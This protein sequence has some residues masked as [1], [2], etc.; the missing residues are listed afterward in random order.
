MKRLPVFLVILLCFVFADP[1]STF[2]KEPST[3]TKKSGL[4][5]YNIVD[6][7]KNKKIQVEVRGAG[8]SKVNVEIKRIANESIQ[9]IIPAG[10]F[11]VNRGN[12]QNMVSTQEVQFTFI[13]DRMANLKVPASCANA[14]KDVPDQNSTFDI[15]QT[16]QSKDL[17][18][19]IVNFGKSKFISN[20]DIV[21]QVAIWIVTDNISRE[22]LDKR[23]VKK[24]TYLGITICPL[25]PDFTLNCPPA[26]SDEDI[27]SAL[28]IVDQAG[29]DVKQKALLTES[30]RLKALVSDNLDF[31]KFSAKLLG[32]TVNEHLGEAVEPL[33]NM[34]GENEEQIKVNAIQALALIGDQKGV[35]ALRGN[36]WAVD[37]LLKILKEKE[38]KVRVRVINA[39]GMIDD[40]RAV[41]PLIA[42]I[43]FSYS[44]IDGPEA[45]AIKNSLVAIGESSWDA[46]LSLLNSDSPGLRVWA[47][48]TLRD[49]P[50]SVVLN[51][52]IAHLEN[53]KNNFQDPDYE[54]ELEV[55]V[56]EIGHVKNS[57]A[58]PAIIGILENSPPNVK[59]AAVDALKNLNDKR[60]VGPLIAALKK[61][62]E[63]DGYVI[64][65]ILAAL[66]KLTKQNFSDFRDWEVWWDEQEKESKS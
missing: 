11:F 35:E 48:K 38:K 24:E 9:I 65:E 51:P 31:K 62:V 2:G 27:I 58:T 55:L 20:T 37:T 47:I 40:P 63:E 39:L 10:T 57:K 60:A 43:E 26:A 33:L 54:Y 59:Q 14:H 22:Y 32:I 53:L 56:N 36:P 18:K 66:K 19:L 21:K 25:F 15:L 52:M 23:F 49:L 46:I 1:G 3:V 29:V 5:P 7:I 28:N 45:S 61:E 64:E 6:A 30:I 42:H 50:E 34:L 17:E 44:E 8:L 12:A 4:N 16:S 41:E 13:K